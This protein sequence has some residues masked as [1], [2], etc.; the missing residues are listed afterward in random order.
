MET[1]ISTEVPRIITKQDYVDF[2][3]A[4]HSWIGYI[5]IPIAVISEHSN[6]GYETKTYL[7]VGRATVPHAK[8]ELFI[9][10]IGKVVYPG[11]KWHVI[12][13]NKV[14]INDELLKSLDFD[15]KDI[16]VKPLG[17]D[18]PSRFNSKYPPTDKTIKEPISHL[19]IGNQIGG[20]EFYLAKVTVKSCI[21]STFYTLLSY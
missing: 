5:Y 15:Y 17:D 19:L 6:F 11:D 18:E 12:S 10:T 8:Y 4:L 2:N 7:A 9:I 21:I 3:E 20:K 13:I 16:H 1:N 14:I